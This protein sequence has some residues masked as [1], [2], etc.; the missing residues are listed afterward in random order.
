MWL[1]IYSRMFDDPSNPSPPATALE[2]V[3]AVF[4]ITLACAGLMWGFWRAHM[5]NC[6]EAEPSAAGELKSDLS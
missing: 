3:D 6:D 5:R 1:D 2:M 4:W